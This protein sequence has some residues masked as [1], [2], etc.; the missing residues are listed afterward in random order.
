MAKIDKLITKLKNNPKN[1]S[2]DEL[3]RVL[4]HFGY[5]EIQLGKT[6][7][8]ARKFKNDKNDIINF[9]E[10]HPDKTL[11]SY[12]IKFVLNKLERN[13]QI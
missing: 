4:S 2:Y 13:G 12:I 10:P 9:H 7:G 1:M 3:V 8:S 5:F 11:K 6:T